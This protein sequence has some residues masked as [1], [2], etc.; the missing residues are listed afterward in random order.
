MPD[1]LPA[2]AFAPEPTP[3]APP[4]APHAVPRVWR[5]VRGPAAAFGDLASP[6]VVH[7]GRFFLRDHPSEIDDSVM[8]AAPRAAE[9][10]EEVEF[11]DL[12]S[13]VAPAP[14][15]KRRRN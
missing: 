10:E 12:A 1:W 4:A 3:S 9:D 8:E 11:V 13:L 5:R 7:A 15:K 2:V 6:D 14:A